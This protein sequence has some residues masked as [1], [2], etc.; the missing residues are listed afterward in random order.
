MKAMAGW[1][2]ALKALA[3]GGA[4][5]GCG[6]ASSPE[7]AAQPPVALEPVASPEPSP[8]NTEG[9]AH[10]PLPAAPPAGL[11]GNTPPPPAPPAPDA[12]TPAPAPDAGTPGARV[13]GVR[14]E[15]DGSACRA[16]PPLPLLFPGP[17]SFVRTGESGRVEERRVHRYDS[18]GRLVATDWLDAA[19]PRVWKTEQRTFDTEGRELSRVLRT[20]S[21]QPFQEE[22]RNTYDARGWLLEESYTRTGPG[23]AVTEELTRY[24][25]DAA[26]RP[27]QV[28]KRHNGV[29]RSV[30]D[31][32]YDSEGRLV[33]ESVASPPAGSRDSK[34]LTRDAAGRLVL[35]EHE[36][37]RREYT[38]RWNVVLGYDAQGRQVSRETRFLSPGWN[39]TH[40]ESTR[41][42][43][44]GGRKVNWV[45]CHGGMRDETYDAEGRLVERN[46]DGPSYS[47]DGGEKLRYGPAGDLAEHSTWSESSQS[48]ERHFYDCR[49]L[50]VRTE[51]SSS[52][53]EGRVDTAFYSSRHVRNFTHDAA[54]N[55]LTREDRLL[56]AYAAPPASEE[57]TFPNSVTWREELGYGCFLPSEET[58]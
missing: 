15:A 4:L 44:G 20:L 33:T 13:P 52:R 46:W 58:R 42:L 24:T 7:H 18:A 10:A 28:E 43:P 5:F 22:W 26:G 48:T 55:L 30:T 40:T 14:A 11:P 19:G 27:V 37:V 29:L 50:R 16:T 53:Q 36:Q 2:A 32:T 12:G 38:V 47:D 34:R 25:H 21:S 23:T 35:E 54:G 56:E 39:C 8:G 41:Y 9:P 6:S 45:D 49:G 31:S 1:R 3:L 57:K 17:C 51:V